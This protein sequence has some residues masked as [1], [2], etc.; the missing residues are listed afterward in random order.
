[1]ENEA[2]TKKLIEEEIRKCIEGLKYVEQG[3]EQH[4]RLVADIQKL[5][6]AYTELD[7]A[8][9]SKIDS[10]RRFKEE[11]RQNDLNREYKDIL[12]RDKMNSEKET[13]KEKIKESKRSGIRDSCIKI[14]GILV[15]GGLFFF[16]TLLGMK[17]EFID[18][19]AMTS[20]TV[21]EMFKGIQHLKM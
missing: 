13:E 20:M 16:F 6:A 4:A 5:T 18:H 11:I 7:K 2:T 17:L 15:Q 10:D 9:Q 8:D 1:M 19:G 3:E 21:K 14:A 12:E